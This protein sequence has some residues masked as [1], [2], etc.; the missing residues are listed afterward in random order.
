MARYRDKM[1]TKADVLDA[2]ADGARKTRI[3]Y[4]ANLSYRLVKKCL[5]ETVKIGF[6][7][8]S[9]RSYEVTERGMV[10]LEKHRDFSA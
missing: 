1:E 10:F 2:A 5:D 9:E 7:I 4:S 8:V 6:V 3:M